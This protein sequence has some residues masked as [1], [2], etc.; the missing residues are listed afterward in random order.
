MT[1]TYKRGVQMSTPQGIVLVDVFEPDLSY[2]E[3]KPILGHL[4]QRRYPTIY[5]QK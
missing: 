4:E 1:A 5:N 2:R 3:P